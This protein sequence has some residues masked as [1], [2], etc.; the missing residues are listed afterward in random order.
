MKKASL[1]LVI[2]A[3]LI[4]P[5]FLRAAQESSA[6]SSLIDSEKNFAAMA[7]DK[8]IQQAFL[9]SLADD[10]V[11][12]RPGP[13]PGKK[14]FEE[15][16][17][18]AGLLT[19]RPALAFVSRSE[20]LGFTMGP[21]E[22]RQKTMN[23]EPAGYGYFVSVWKKQEDGT[24]QVLIDHG[25]DYAKPGLAVKEVKTL[26]RPAPSKHPAGSPEAEKQSLVNADLALQKLISEKG[27]AAAYAAWLAND[28]RMLRNQQ[29]PLEGK[30]EILGVL[31]EEK[32]DKTAESLAGAGV[33]KAADLGYS[34]GTAGEKGSYVRIW[35]KTSKGRWNIILDM[36]RI[37]K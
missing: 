9:S 33:S 20:D 2:S 7:A 6:L 25:I 13:V 21:W 4:F 35:R 18:G 15:H 11:I 27:P 5:C 1:L 19:W 26:S 30:T 12:F 8:G 3:L 16:P 29:L 34:Y 37:V 22:Y 24:W 36:L 23:E 10:S 31:K 32:P 14:W 17:Q 28:A